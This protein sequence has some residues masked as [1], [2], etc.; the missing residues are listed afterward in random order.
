MWRSP[1]GRGRPGRC[2]LSRGPGR[3]G[4]D[5]ASPIPD[6]A[7]GSTKTNVMRAIAGPS[8]D[9]P[10]VEAGARRRRAAVEAASPSVPAQPDRS[11]AA[12]GCMA[13]RSG[14]HSGRQSSAPRVARR[15][16]DAVGDQGSD[17]VGS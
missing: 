12:A 10:P 7:S 9:L 13:G 16:G 17:D 14:A 3:G 6:N 8:H 2:T 4:V 5:E 1:G 15:R 11:A